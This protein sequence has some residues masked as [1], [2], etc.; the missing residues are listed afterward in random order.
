MKRMKNLMTFS[1]HL[2]DKNENSESHQGAGEEI[3]EKGTMANDETKIF[4]E[5]MT[6]IIMVQKLSN[7]V[8]VW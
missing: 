2:K 5:H 4:R 3:G 6:K 1:I 8:A 7:L